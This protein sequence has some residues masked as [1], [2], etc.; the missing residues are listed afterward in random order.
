MA[1]SG[2]PSKLSL[3]QK[4]ASVTG[5]APV[6]AFNCVIDESTKAHPF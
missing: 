6:Q 5:T 4:S 3:D 1:A 2:R